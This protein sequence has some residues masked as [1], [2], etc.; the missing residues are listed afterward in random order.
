MLRSN[1]DLRHSMLESNPKKPLAKIKIVFVFVKSVSKDSY[2]KVWIFLLTATLSIE[3]IGAH[4]HFHFSNP[5]HLLPD[6][7]R[8]AEA[9]SVVTDSLALTA[10]KSNYGPL[11]KKKSQN[12][13]KETKTLFLDRKIFWGK[14]GNRNFSKKLLSLRNGVQE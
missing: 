2:Q 8:T 11:L 4:F 3:M 6:I 14:S 9:A 13:F 5:R 10:F 12:I 1:E 7:Q